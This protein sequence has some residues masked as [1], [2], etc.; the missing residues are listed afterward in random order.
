MAELALS[1][2]DIVQGLRGHVV[3]VPALEDELDR[4]ILRLIAPPSHYV[5][6]DRS[7]VQDLSPQ[8][9][10]KGHVQNYDH[11]LRV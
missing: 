3:R 10:S 2:H 7:V 8:R 1:T 4:D 11:I 9:V 5:Q 6:R